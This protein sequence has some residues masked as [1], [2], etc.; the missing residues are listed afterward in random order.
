MKTK[1]VHLSLKGSFQVF[2]D[3]NGLGS[4]QGGD[5]EGGVGLRAE[6]TEKYRNTQ[7]MSEIKKI[8]RS[9]SFVRFLQQ[10]TD[11]L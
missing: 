4:G 9:F 8:K 2:D 10:H 5:R 11:F 6:A 1:T 7:E 3:N